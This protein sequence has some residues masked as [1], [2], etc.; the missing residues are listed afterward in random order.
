MDDEKSENV[1]DLG[2]A[3]ARRHAAEKT[4]ADRRAAHP[5]VIGEFDV[6]FIEGDHPVVIIFDLEEGIAANL[7]R[8]GALGLAQALLEADA[9]PH[10]PWNTKAPPSSVLALAPPPEP[11][12]H[13]PAPTYHP[14]TGT[15]FVRSL[16]TAHCDDTVVDYARPVKPERNWVDYGDDGEVVSAG[17]LSEEAFATLTASYELRLRE[18]EANGGRLTIPGPETIEGEFLCA[19]GSWTKACTTRDATE[20]RWTE[21]GGP[22]AAQ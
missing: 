16:I 7:T 8:E 14:G 12:W 18:W 22:E 13:P 21:S 3:R 1:V 5:A 6:G 15:P 2:R 20:W 17:K 11:L 19:D 9:S 4:I 10:A